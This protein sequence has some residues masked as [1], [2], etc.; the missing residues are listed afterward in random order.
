MTPTDKFAPDKLPEGK[1]VESSATRSESGN[2]PHPVRP[3]DRKGPLGP[4]VTQ[5]ADSAA[6]LTAVA[7]ARSKIQEDA[8]ARIKSDPR[9][10]MDQEIFIAGKQGK[11]GV[12]DVRKTVEQLK[13]EGKQ[14]GGAEGE[15]QSK[16]AAAKN[17]PD[18]S[19]V[20]KS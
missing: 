17:Q 9:Y 14:L 10:E 4:A 2:N 7:E 8:D 15:K 1:P 3:E 11:L 6:Q 16:E 18:T 19:K 12:P 5:V 20:I 13:A